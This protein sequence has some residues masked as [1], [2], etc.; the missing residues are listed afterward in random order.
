[1]YRNLYSKTYIKC[2][3]QLLIIA[4]YNCRAKNKKKNGQIFYQVFRDI[5]NYVCMVISKY[6]A[7]VEGCIIIQSQKRLNSSA[8][9][10][11][12]ILVK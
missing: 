1:M 3:S 11:I 8:F 4:S 12:N 9:L 5:Q 6:F 2:N 10:E 7:H